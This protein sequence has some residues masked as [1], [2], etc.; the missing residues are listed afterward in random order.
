M[1]ISNL[2]GKRVVVTG[3][4]SGIGRATALEFARRGADLA[5]CDLNEAGLSETTKELEALGSHVIARRTD[6]SDRAEVNAF[7]EDVHRE[8]EAV[9][10][11]MNNAGVAIGGGFLDTSL[12]DF[13]WIFGINVMG[14]VH[15]SHYFVPKMVARNRG[16]HVINVASAA[17]YVA[18]EALAAYA[19][20]KFA[21]V[22]LSEA[23]RDELR[24]ARI[25]VTA[26]CPGI[27]NTPITKAA[28]LRGV[29]AHPAARKRMVEIY[30]R[31]GY[32]AERV[33]TNILKAVQR[34][35]SVAPISPE[36]WGMYF[37][38]RFTPGLV[39]WLNRQV[40]ARTRREFEALAAQ[41]PSD[42]PS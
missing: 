20:T 39:A 5:I 26:I 12:D 2:R 41:S 40:S 4:A 22:G 8:V 13:E 16:G 31:R 32:T 25:G 34:N 24:P 38:K 30:E 28:K 19:S 35:R 6:V 14:V 36:A 23:M 3:A 17:G 11:L 42:D 10:I 9:D 7:A 33:A 18:T 29:N 1:D 27:I 15:G 21:V 37:M